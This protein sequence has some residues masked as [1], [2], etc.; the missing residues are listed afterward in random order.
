MKSDSI[1]IF[2]I[3][4]LVG[5][6]IWKFTQNSKQVIDSDPKIYFFDESAGKLFKGPQSSIPPIRGIDGDQLDGVRAVVIQSNQEGVSQQIAYLEK[7]SPQLKKDIEMS[8][9]AEESGGFYERV[10]GR[11]E[12]KAHI[13]VRK[14]NSDKWYPMSSNEGNSISSYWQIEDKDGNMPVIVNPK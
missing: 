2:A 1:K 13:L 8:R 6:A 3:V 9:K 5:F 12:S 10:I 7:F 14:P 11:S 4:L